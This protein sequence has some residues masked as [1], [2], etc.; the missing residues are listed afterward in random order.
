MKRHPLLLTLSLA[1][2]LCAGCSMLKK[3]DKPKD[4]GAIATETDAALQQRWV[5]KR[6]AE[7]VAQGVAA[8]AAKA[9]A[10]EE[11]RVKYSFTGA[12]KK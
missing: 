1:A 7:L 12:A 10:L 9:Q 2:A 5:D 11:F 4:T 6:V 8:D 3:S